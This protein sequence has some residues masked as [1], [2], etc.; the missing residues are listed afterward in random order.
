ML[1]E[2]DLFL[3]TGI[4]GTGKTHLH[5]LYLHVS[6]VVTGAQERQVSEEE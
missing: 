6:L 4:P 1:Q 3:I 5:A 2:C